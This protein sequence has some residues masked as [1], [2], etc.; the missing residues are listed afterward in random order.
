MDG[1]TDIHVVFDAAKYIHY[2]MVFVLLFMFFIKAPKT[3]MQYNDF[4]IYLILFMLCVVSFVNG[5]SQNLEVNIK[6]FV[7]TFLLVFLNSRKLS[8]TLI[9]KLFYFVFAILLIEYI[10]VYAEIFPTFHKYYIRAYHLIRPVGPFMDMQLLSYFVVFT[11]FTFGYTKISGLLSIFFG[12]YQVVLGWVVLA[13]KKVNK[14]FYVA[15]VILLA[16]TLYFVGHLNVPV[17]EPDSVKVAPSMLS[18][19]LSIY[20]SRINYQCLFFGCS[21]NIDTV[22]DDPSVNDFGFYRV[23]YQFGLLWLVMLIV[24]LKR[25]S[26]LFILANVVMWVHYP[27]TLGILGFVIFIWILNIMKYKEDE[28][29]YNKMVVR[30][31]NSNIQNST[32]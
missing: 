24:S 18:I 30:V 1:L 22:I 9:Y 32:G 31:Q 20:D 26:K 6:P 3:R 19:L 12:S 8:V 16:I 10:I 17:I 2:P 13:S 7:I 5:L 4:I 11:I 23:M 15:I 21:I 27:L 14:L 25:Y 28:N 29:K